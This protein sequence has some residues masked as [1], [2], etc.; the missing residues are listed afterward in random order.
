[1]PHRAYR[2]TIGVDARG[3]PANRAHPLIQ[4]LKLTIFFA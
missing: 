2:G 4:G 1:M 3:A